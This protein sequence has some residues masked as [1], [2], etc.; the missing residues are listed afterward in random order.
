MTKN[1]V[2]EAEA[3][4][5]DALAEQQRAKELITSGEYSDAIV[6]AHRCMEMCRQVAV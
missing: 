1:D 3:E 2:L 5:K 4:M 6:S